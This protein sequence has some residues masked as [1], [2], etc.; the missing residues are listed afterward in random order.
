MRTAARSGAKYTM[1]LPISRAALAHIA[2]RFSTDIIVAETVSIPLSESEC[3]EEFGD[4]LRLWC[5]R[6]CRGKWRQVGRGVHRAVALAFESAI[7]AAMFRVAA[8]SACR[9]VITV[10]HLRRHTLLKS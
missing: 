5:K 6:H 1:E 3:P 8:Y 4:E 9:T 2:K 7:D 10:R